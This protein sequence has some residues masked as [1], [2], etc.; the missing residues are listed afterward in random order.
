MPF[1]GVS[2]HQDGA[3]MNRRRY[4]RKAICLLAGLAVAAMIPM[5]TRADDKQWRMMTKPSRAPFRWWPGNHSGRDR[6][7]TDRRHSVCRSGHHREPAYRQNGITPK[8][9]GPGQRSS[10][11]QPSQYRSALIPLPLIMRTTAS[12]A[13]AAD[14]D[15]RVIFFG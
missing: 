3:A 1:T 8:G 12:M 15:G 9:A 13:S 2:K 11:R 7:R 6:R 10:N 5:S 14:V 4:T